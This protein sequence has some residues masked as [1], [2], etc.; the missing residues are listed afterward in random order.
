M[1]SI[2]NINN[3]I[4]GIIRSSKRPLLI[5]LGNPLRRDDGVG[6]YVYKS[7]SNLK[8]IPITYCYS[9]ELCTDIIAEYKPDT[10]IILDAI[11]AGIEPGDLVFTC[12]LNTIIEE[13]L[14]TTHTVPL[15]LV[16]R[17]LKETIPTI[18][19]ICLLGVQIKDRGIGEG[20]SSEVEKTTRYIIDLLTSIFPPS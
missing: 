10:I 3:S 9:L 17:Y 2:K 6:Y 13:Y 4:T 15:S 19:R 5:A 16:I 12:D 1:G 18:K 8:S 11:D 20:L 7:L 14:P